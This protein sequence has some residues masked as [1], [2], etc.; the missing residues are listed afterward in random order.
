MQSRKFQYLWLVRHAVAMSREDWIHEDR[1]RPLTSD[2]KRKFLNHLKNLPL[3]KW[4]KGRCMLV[5][6][7]LTRAE[8][9]ATLFKNYIK[10]FPKTEMIDFRIRSEFRPHA[11]IIRAADWIRHELHLHQN[12]RHLLIFGHEPQLS[13]LLSHLLIGDEDSLRTDF[14]KGAIAC[15][16]F[17]FEHFD[18]VGLF[19]PELFPTDT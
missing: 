14:K 12:L 6:S 10:R 5:H 4:L 1:F 13:G 2:G 8:Q 9:T 11:K 3:K 15:L 18:L 7:G 17:E 19:P 16:S